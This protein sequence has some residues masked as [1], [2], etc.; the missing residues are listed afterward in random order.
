M[1]QDM[2][3]ARTNLPSPARWLAKA[4]VA[5]VQTRG[6]PSLSA[7]LFIIDTSYHITV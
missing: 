5:Y 6:P 3:I 1:H 7:R 4:D 2:G